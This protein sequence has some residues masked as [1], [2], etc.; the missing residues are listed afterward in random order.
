MKFITAKPI[1]TLRTIAYGLALAASK[2]TAP[3]NPRTSW[4]CASRGRRCM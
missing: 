4:R 2:P 1:N 3:W